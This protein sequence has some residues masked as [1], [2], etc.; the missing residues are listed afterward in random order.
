MKFGFYMCIITD[1]V[2]TRREENPL[3][4]YESIKWE[5]NRRLIIHEGGRSSEGV[6]YCLLQCLLQ[7]DKGRAIKK[8]NVWLSVWYMSVGVMKDS[9]LKL[10]DFH[11]TSYDVVYY[12]GE[13]EIQREEIRWC[14]CSEGQRPEAWGFQGP[15][16]TGLIIIHTIWI[17]RSHR[18]KSRH[19]PCRGRVAKPRNLCVCVIEECEDGERG[20]REGEGTQA[21]FLSSGTNRIHNSVTENEDR[22][23]N[24]LWI[25]ERKLKIKPIYECRCNGRLQTKR[26]IRLTH[27][28]LVVELEH[29]RLM[30]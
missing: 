7:V 8:T 16:H 29:V 14:R 9:K 22:F 3:I 27:T 1:K 11:H 10:R 2:R 17:H 4:N 30:T 19:Q 13:N 26:F 20:K 18:S 23:M 21:L 25:N 24:Q 28:G 5:L 12:N 6:V 15:S